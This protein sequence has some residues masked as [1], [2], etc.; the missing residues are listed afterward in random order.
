[1]IISNKPSLPAGLSSACQ[2]HG[3]DKDEYGY[4][5]D[6]RI[7]EGCI[8]GQREPDIGQHPG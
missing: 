1:M 2:I 4:S 3:P 5:T 7:E 6:Q 8:P